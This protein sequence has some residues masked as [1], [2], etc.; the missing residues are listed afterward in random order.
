[1]DCSIRLGSPGL[2]SCDTWSVAKAAS[3]DGSVIVGDPFQGSG[4]CTFIWEAQHG[5]RSL[6]EVLINDYG[7]DLTGWQLSE[8]RGISAD[9]NTI[10]GFGTNPAGQNEGWIANLAPSLAISLSAGDVILS[11]PTNA[12]GFVLERTLSLSSSNAW[13]TN[14]APVCVVGA[15]FAITNSLGAAQQFF[16]LKKP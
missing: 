10:V 16:R 5:I 12:P 14:S 8:A 2:S 4:D 13:S 9:G 3:A 7:L 15:S 1:M 6:H 11:W